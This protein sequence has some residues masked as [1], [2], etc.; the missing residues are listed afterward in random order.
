MALNLDPPGTAS[1]CSKSKSRLD[2]HASDMSS[3]PWRDLKKTKTALLKPLVA[4]VVDVEEEEEEEEEVHH[5]HPYLCHRLSKAY[6]NLLL[7]WL[8]CIR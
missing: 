3:P 1:E 4:V 6:G 7:R 5:C 2:A 8:D